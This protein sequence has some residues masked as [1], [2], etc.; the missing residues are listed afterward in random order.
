MTMSNSKEDNSQCGCQGGDNDGTTTTTGTIY[1]YGPT[2]M[3]H[4]YGKNKND[5]RFRNYVTPKRSAC[6]ASSV[7][8]ISS[9]YQTVCADPR[10]GSIPNNAVTMIDLMEY[11][12]AGT[13]P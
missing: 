4:V 5:A 10:K 1:E 12:L 13:L 11:N 6:P 7:I 3:F 9:S 2:S 8:S